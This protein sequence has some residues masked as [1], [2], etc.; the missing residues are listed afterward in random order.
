MKI[1]IESHGTSN[2][3]PISCSVS[4]LKGQVF[5]IEILLNSECK[6]TPTCRIIS[7]AVSEKR[8]LSIIFS[9]EKGSSALNFF[10]DKKEE[11]SLYSSKVFVLK[12]DG[13]TYRFMCIPEKTIAKKKD[14]LKKDL[15]KATVVP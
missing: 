14:I 6:S 8:F 3:K 11:M 13:N 4:G 7:D 1:E 9:D 15:S 2:L 12:A 10:T 5:L